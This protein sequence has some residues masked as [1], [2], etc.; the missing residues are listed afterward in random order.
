MDT[1]MLFILFY[2]KKYTLLQGNVVNVNL[3]TKIKDVFFRKYFS[4]RSQQITY[5]V[6]SDLCHLC[7][8]SVIFCAKCRLDQSRTISASQLDNHLHLFSDN[9][10][11]ELTHDHI[12]KAHLD[13]IDFNRYVSYKF[14]LCLAKDLPL[15]KFFK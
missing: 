5:C 4:I 6:A 3:K 13:F 11:I 14:F 7:Q 10:F 8:K 1:E 2:Q 15:F 9:T 12:C